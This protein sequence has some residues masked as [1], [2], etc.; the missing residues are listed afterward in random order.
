TCVWS[1]AVPFLGVYLC[2]RVRS[3]PYEGNGKCVLLGGSSG[4]RHGAGRSDAFWV[5]EPTITG[6][7]V[8]ETGGR[9]RGVRLRFRRL[10]WRPQWVGGVST[11]R[12]AEHS[13]GFVAATEQS[14]GKGET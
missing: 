9:A 4:I 10:L 8:V 11:D 12:T 14:P 2:V 13:S 7:V 1:C 3:D 6:A 5:H